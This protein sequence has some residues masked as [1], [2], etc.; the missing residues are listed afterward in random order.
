[1]IIAS[2]V[3]DLIYV[4]KDGVTTVAGNE[5]HVPKNC[6]GNRNWQIWKSMLV[7]P[8]ANG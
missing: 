4:N 8:K 1:M 5:F 6:P 7:I 3:H 2:I